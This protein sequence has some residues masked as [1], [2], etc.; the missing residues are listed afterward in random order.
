MSKTY[1]ESTQSG[2]A[3]N[4]AR[5]LKATS[6][7][8][9]NESNITL[10]RNWSQQ[11][12][13][14]AAGKNDTI[15]M[16]RI[17]IRNRTFSTAELKFTDTTLGGSYAINAKP[18][19]TQY[20]D[21]RAEGRLADRRETS[22]GAV[23]GK[24]GLGSYYS[25]AIDDNNQLI[26]LRFGVPNY[27][28]LTQFFTGF[29]NVHAGRLA[30]TGRAS[31]FFGAAAETA[32]FV[33]GVVAQITFFPLLA[34]HALGY[35]GNFFFGKKT[36]KFYYLKPTMTPYWA[37]V[38]SM[39]N[40]IAVGRGLFPVSL[41][42]EK[43]QT[44]NTSYQLDSTV[45]KN[46]SSMMP[47]VFSPDGGYDIYAAAN[48]AERYRVASDRRLYE[49]FNKGTATD[50]YGVVQ[51]EGQNKLNKLDG[52][53]SGFGGLRNAIRQFITAPST[54]ITPSAN[55]NAD[56]SGPEKDLR[57]DG[58]K[59][60]NFVQKFLGYLTN[61][62]NDGAAFATF[63]VD[64]TGSVSESFSNS[65]RE[66]DI[67]SKA[68]SVASQARST[69]FTFA[70]GN[71]VG[72]ALGAAVG[73]ATDVV[74]GFITGTLDSM[75][76]SGLL[77]LAGGSFVDIP[78]HWD[79]SSAN[80]PKSSYTIQLRSPYGNVVSQMQNLYIPLAMLLAGAL[81]LSTGK[82]SYTSPFIL[83]IYD[84]GRNQ[85]RLG[86]IDSLSVTRGTTNLG[87]DRN[88]NAMGIDVSF[89]I[90]DMSSIMHMQMSK[91]FV[92]LTDD[93]GIFDEE[94]VFSDYMNTLSSLGLKEQIHSVALGYLNA[95]RSVRNL[96]TLTSP[97]AW[98]SIVKQYTPVGLLE[99]FYA[100][101][102]RQ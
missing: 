2:A 26:H 41:R 64:Y 38:G 27:N 95:A 34:V 48:K 62:L 70:G 10:D 8:R 9:S 43:N 85:T 6:L 93:N 15:P 50:F 13:M 56:T 86:M 75:Q 42:R 11:A 37:A 52:T 44:I 47:D 22:L 84:R 89:S 63:R 71:V 99:V 102:R 20:A 32:G 67:S 68:N 61:E 79:S 3:V 76:F 24:L 55:E 25:E 74:G 98:A 33:F 59:D 54:F 19:F 29:Y 69:K 40:K 53:H 5:P 21:I 35:V 1:N 81:P 23:N 82:Q 94:T 60:S 28:S 101:T 65:V 18:Q 92:S 39:V 77:G 16:A 72:G 88:G 17:D 57:A 14:L 12:F 83:E 97:A 96:Q 7:L 30:R 78:K 90:V 58:N 49:A 66:S 4:D 80:L 51:A 46:L 31:T 45:L 73:V 100:G 36:S 91:G 87:F